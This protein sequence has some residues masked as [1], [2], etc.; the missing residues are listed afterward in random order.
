VSW[1]KSRNN[2]NKYVKRMDWRK[3]R[4]YSLPQRNQV[5]IDWRIY[6]MKNLFLLLRLTFYGQWGTLLKTWLLYYPIPHSILIFFLAPWRVLSFCLS[7][8]KHRFSMDWEIVKLDWSKKGD[9]TFPNWEL[10]LFEL[11]I[12]AL[13]LVII[14]FIQS[15]DSFIFCS[16]IQLFIYLFVLWVAYLF[17]IELHFFRWHWQA[18]FEFGI[19]KPF[20]FVPNLIYFAEIVKLLLSWVWGLKHLP[21]SAIYVRSVDLFEAKEKK[22]QSLAF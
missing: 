17:G 10:H 14:A 3:K 4:V 9:N 12:A 6:L 22:I 16:G 2:F 20:R 5:R 1:V 13:Q 11:R 18:I 15:F 7:D 19:C 8:R 21:L